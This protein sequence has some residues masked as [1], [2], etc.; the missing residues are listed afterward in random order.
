MT[1][2]A[3]GGTRQIC[4]NLLRWIVPATWMIA[5]IPA[6]CTNSRTVA[7]LADDDATEADDDDSPM[8][9]ADG[10]G[11]PAAEDCDDD[12]PA[13]NHDDADGDGYS[14]CGGDCDDTNAWFHPGAVDL[15]GD[16]VDGDCDGINPSAGGFATWIS[17]ETSGG[18]EG[19]EASVSYELRIVD[20]D[21]EDICTVTLAFSAEYTHGSQDEDFWAHIDQIVT[22]SALESIEDG[23]PPE[24]VPSYLFIDD[25]VTEWRWRSGGHP[26]AFV[27]CDRI[28]SDPT[29]ADTFLGDDAWGFGADGSFGEACTVM[30]PAA[31]SAFVTGPVEGVWLM[32]GKPGSLDL[33]GDFAY[34]EP[35]DTTQTEA[36][37]LGGLVMASADNAA[38]PTPGLEGT[39]ECLPGW[40][41]GFGEL[42]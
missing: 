18:E 10:D 7:V 35:A 42:W 20:H 14:T 15:W 22:L 36:W 33:W 11:Y 38:E 8:D 30:G 12:D 25:P 13:L 1:G 29:L 2:P 40:I 34:L 27:S 4:E 17:L 28:A 6:G 24:V 31:A 21:W 16:G 41:W 26:L 23:C 37:M 9:D 3:R 32:A 39:Y 19:G 5:G